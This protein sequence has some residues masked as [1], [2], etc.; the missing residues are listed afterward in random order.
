[1]FERRRPGLRAA[2]VA[3]AVAVATATGAGSAVAAPEADPVVAPAFHLYGVHKQTHELWEWYHR[4][5]LLVTDGPDI[6]GPD[7]GDQSD[8]A[9]II[10]VD[11]SSDSYGAGRGDGYW[12]LYK[13]GRL[14]FAGWYDGQWRGPKNVGRG[15]DIY[16]TV[17]SPGTLGGAKE[18]DLI[19][20]DRAGVLWS[21]LGYPDGRVTTRMRVGGGWG[22]YT[23]LA[24][25]GDLTGDGRADITA[26]D[27]AGVLWLYKGTG[28]YKAPFAGRTK[29]GG[30]WNAYDRLLS[31]GD[32]DA[33]GKVD[34]LAR[35]TTGELLRYSG[36]GNAARPFTA[37]VQ[38]KESFMKEYNL[39]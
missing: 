26:R 32:S 37:P 35:K 8:L 19:G 3:T 21:Y 4:G 13:N 9:D 5:P 18:A 20:L 27:K 29:I 28:D 14:D 15:W 6:S 16:R 1:M 36:T 22:Q 12:T 10:T 24:G 23:E 7:A 30:G 34:L 25:Q 11:N 39:L 38:I 31:L 2:L 33:D 17:L